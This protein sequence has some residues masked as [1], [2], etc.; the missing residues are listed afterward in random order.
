MGFSCFLYIFSR[1]QKKVLCMYVFIANRC[2]HMF[3]ST[4]ISTILRIQKSAFTYGF[5]GNH[6]HQE[7]K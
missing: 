7:G 4:Q 3:I 5:G 2:K 1:C 6:G